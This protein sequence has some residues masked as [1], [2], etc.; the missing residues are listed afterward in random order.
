MPETN[1]NVAD[2][3]KKQRE[4]EENKVYYLRIDFVRL[5]ELLN[6]YLTKSGIRR[7][8]FLGCCSNP[9]LYKK[10]LDEG[11][12]ITGKFV[13]E[14]DLF[15]VNRSEDGVLIKSEEFETE[16]IYLNKNTL[17][18]SIKGIDEERTKIFPVEYEFLG[19]PEKIREAYKQYKG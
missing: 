3:I 18:F 9:N 11:Y 5:N 4:E 15:L 8:A 6:I 12:P 7:E 19:N 2:M 1:E 17:N 10:I 14:L 16:Y 13:N